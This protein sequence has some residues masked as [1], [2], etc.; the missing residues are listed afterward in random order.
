ML[1]FADIDSLVDVLLER[2]DSDLSAGTDS[3]ALRLATA[4]GAMTFYDE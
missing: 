4:F 2:S 1:R 3:E